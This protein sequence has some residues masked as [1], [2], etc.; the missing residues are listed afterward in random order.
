M[1][2][3]GYPMVVQPLSEED[4]GGFIALAPDLKGCMADGETPE[5]AISDLLSAIEEWID[6]AIRLKLHIPEPYT[7]ARR[8]HAEREEIKNLIEAQDA[9]IKKQEDLIVAARSELANIRN[10]I[11]AD[12][13]GSETVWTLA[14]VGGQT[15]RPLQDS[16]RRNVT[17]AH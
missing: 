12:Y 8:A 4:G 9:L 3:R 13:D 15:L 7:V 16:K 10:S 2:D 14:I 1:I 17:I 11:K 6:E 5:A